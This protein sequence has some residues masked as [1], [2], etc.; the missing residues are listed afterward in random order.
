MK[1]TQNMR[2]T[3]TSSAKLYRKEKQI[4]RERFAESEELKNAVEQVVL[5]RN[6]IRSRAEMRKRNKVRVAALATV[7]Q[8]LERA[9][10]AN[11]K[12]IAT[13][14]NVAL[15]LLLLDQDLAYFSN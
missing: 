6:R 4:Q 9:E 14:F 13:I 11:A 12:N 1:F 15:Y 8:T 7:R 10:K 5:L 3:L 2:Q